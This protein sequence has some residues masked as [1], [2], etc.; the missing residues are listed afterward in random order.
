MLLL[1]EVRVNRTAVKLQAFKLQAPEKPQA[2]SSNFGAHLRA[3]LELGFSLELGRL[4]LFTVIS[5]ASP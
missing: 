2:S 3:L 5:Y 1:N 4:E